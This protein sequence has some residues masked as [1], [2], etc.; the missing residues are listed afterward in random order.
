MVQQSLSAGERQPSSRRRWSR[1]TTRA[2]NSACEARNSGFKPCTEGPAG[3]TRAIFCDQISCRPR[4]AGHHKFVSRIHASLW[5]ARMLPGG[6]NWEQ[7]QDWASSGRVAH[8]PLWL[9]RSWCQNLIHWRM[10]GSQSWVFIRREWN[11]TSRSFLSI[12]PIRCTST[13]AHSVRGDLLRWN[14]LKG[15]SFIFW[16]KGRCLHSCLPTKVGKV[17][18]VWRPVSKRKVHFCHFLPLREHDGDV[19]CGKP[20]VHFVEFPGQNSNWTTEQWIDT[21]RKG[22]DKIRFEYSLGQSGRSFR[23][24]SRTAESRANI[25]YGWMDYQC[26]VGSTWIVHASLIAGGKG[27]K[28]GR[29]TCFLTTIDPLY[30]FGVDHPYEEGITSYTSQQA[31]VEES[32]RCRLLVRPENVHKIKAHYFGK[33]CLMPSYSTT[34]FQMIAWSKCLARRARTCTSRRR[35][36]LKPFPKSC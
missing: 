2:C 31:K 27:S 9:V 35:L 6:G 29:Q 4:R 7:Y 18:I 14:F 23:K 1:S 10:M 21:R 22:T 17:F 34:S 11:G 15:N 36:N 19:S 32:A 12:A 8:K 26:H 30:I 16:S 20:V 28:Q 33:R 3:C 25:F 5:Q 24:R 13:Q